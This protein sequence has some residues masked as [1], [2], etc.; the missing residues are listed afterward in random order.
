MYAIRSYYALADRDIDAAV[1]GGPA[2]VEDILVEAGPGFN[3]GVVKD[4]LILT[5]VLMPGETADEH[6]P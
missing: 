6:G 2:P 5:A 3:A 1:A 4:I